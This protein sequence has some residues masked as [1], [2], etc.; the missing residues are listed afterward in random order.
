MAMITI[1]R[2][3]DRAGGEHRVYECLRCGLVETTTDQS[4]RELEFRQQA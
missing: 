4:D 2:T 3:D 1:S